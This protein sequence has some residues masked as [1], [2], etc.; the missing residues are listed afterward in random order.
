MQAAKAHSFLIQ[1]CIACHAAT[2][3]VLASLLRQACAELTVATCNHGI[4]LSWTVD[5][6]VCGPTTAKLQDMSEISWLVCMSF[7]W[8]C[9]TCVV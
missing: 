1:A 2:Q 4:Y 3:P 9:V 6:C 7:W 8:F 5:G